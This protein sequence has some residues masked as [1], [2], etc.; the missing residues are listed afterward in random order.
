MCVVGRRD[1]V[2]CPAI[3]RSIFKGVMHDILS[4]KGSCKRSGIFYYKMESYDNI[5]IE[6]NKHFILFIYLYLFINCGAQTD[7][8]ERLTRKVPIVWKSSR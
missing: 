3:F 1:D 8:I 4:P 6:K 7:L 2:S 5:L